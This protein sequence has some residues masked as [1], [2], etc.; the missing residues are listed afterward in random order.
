MP[1]CVRG[2]SYR[3]CQVEDMEKVKNFRHMLISRAIKMKTEVTQDQQTTC[4][5]VAVFQ[6]CRQLFNKRESVSLFLRLGG[7]RD[8]KY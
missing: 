4:N 8:R 6:K 5:R 7:G 3:L 2:E 1:M